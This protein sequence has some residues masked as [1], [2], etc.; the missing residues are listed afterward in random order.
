[1]DQLRAM[2]VFVRVI[3]EGGFARAAKAMNIAPAVA[4]RL[5]VELEEHLGARLIHR[6]TRRLTLTEV[7][8]T[9]LERVRAILTEVDDAE[10]AANAATA[11]PR[12]TLRVV[13]PPG[14]AF[15]QLAALLPGFRARFPKVDVELTVPGMVETVDDTHDV[16]ILVAQRPLEGGFVARTLAVSEVVLC[17]S[18][19]YLKRHGTPEHPRDLLDHETLLPVSPSVRRELDFHPAHGGPPVRV[20]MLR[21]PALVTTHSDTLFAAALAG[22]G[23]SGLPSFVAATA[24]RRG[25]IVRLLP[26]WRLR[27][28]PVLAAMPTR[29]HV[30]VRTRAFIDYLVECLGG[31]AKD[32]WLSAAGCETCP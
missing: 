14:F 5:I 11:E 2:R 31:E 20:E 22:L 6:T 7:G 17:A 19:A 12:G 21:T 18:P 29:K 30:P 27:Q 15:H 13:A 1:M 10:A 28:L 26:H 32:P 8:E 4:T 23:I 16:S 24:L 25:E 9:Y 3:D